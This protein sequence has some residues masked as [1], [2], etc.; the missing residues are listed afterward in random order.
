MRWTRKFEKDAKQGS[1]SGRLQPVQCDAECTRKTD[2]S[3]TKIVFK[4]I[5]RCKKGRSPL[6][7]YFQAQYA[8]KRLSHVCLKGVIAYLRSKRGH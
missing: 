6:K 1:A 8:H 4:S 5:T 3:A 2:P 7:N